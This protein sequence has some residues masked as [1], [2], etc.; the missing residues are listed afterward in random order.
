[1][2]VTFDFYRALRKQLKWGQGL[3]WAGDVLFSLTALLILLLSFQKA[4][5]LTF[6]FYLF[7]GSL[8]GLIIYLSFFSKGLRRL[9]YYLFVFVASIARVVG[10]LLQI[11]W[12]LIVI[13]MR[14]PYAVVRWVSMLLYRMSG[15][16]VVPLLEKGRRVVRNLRLRLF[17][18][19]ID[20]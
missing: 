12:R 5:F 1:V 8:L 9:F 19:H 14:P 18:P 7:G 15:T 16:V 6:R 2:G 17:P 4:N 20:S 11:P 10:L 3:T 13:L